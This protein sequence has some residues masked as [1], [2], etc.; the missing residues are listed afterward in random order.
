[1]IRSGYLLPNISQGVAIALLSWLVVLWLVVAAGASDGQVSSPEM[2]LLF[3]SGNDQDVAALVTKR[4]GGKILADG[5][6]GATIR[7]GAGEYLVL[8]AQRVINPRGGAV[9]FWVRPQWKPEDRGS[10]TF[11][12][13]PWADSRTGY[14]A[15]SY[16]W[17]EPAGKDLTYVIGNNLEHANVARLIRYDLH[18]WTH[19]VCVWGEGTPGFIRLY[20]NGLKVGEDNRYGGDYQA[21]SV[22]H[23]GAD[24]GTPLAAGRWA[25]ADFSGVSF[26][27][28]PLSD[29]AV[30]KLYQ[31]DAAAGHLIT[32]SRD[33]VSRQIRA[34]FDEGVGWMSERGARETIRRIKAAGFNVFIPCVW[35]GG[36]T[37]YPSDSA[38]PEHK[39]MVAGTD[40]LKR[41]IDI[42]HANA[43]EVHPWF[44]VTLRENA[45]FPEYFDTNTPA[46]AYDI[47]R[48]EFQRF[49]VELIADVAR[50]YQID[51]VNLD[52]IRTMG[53]CTCSFCTREY[54]HQ[55]G[56]DLVVD[57]L[58]VT[59]GVP[60]EPALQAW[61][62]DAVESLVRQISQRVKS[63]RPTAI[64][65]VDGHPQ[66]FDDREGRQEA[67]WTNAEL[68]DL[69]FN[70]DY[71]NP[72]DAE[73]HHGV[74]TSFQ[75]PWRLI[76]LISNY[77]WDGQKVKPKSAG[78]LRRNVDYLLRRWPGGIGIYLYSMLNDEQAGMFVSGPF[79]TN[80]DKSGHNITGKRQPA[81]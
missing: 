48:H 75:E 13:F 45:A 9:S 19:L 62:D 35:H 2:R 53:I 29:E 18:Q 68:V 12:S 56:R 66:P 50:R 47:H 71:G 20:V 77:D 21:G 24:K 10:H 49:M 76:P 43:I 30:F 65:S 57:V 5:I 70:M 14:F 79:A 46:K 38:P 40:P 51:G 63:L 32:T 61:Q 59:P 73:R 25:H 15:V 69:V 3:R 37:R 7:L 17:W 44:T 34:I 11:L 60:L 39:K 58:A 36:G 64:I 26:F 33:P 80:Y 52:Y 78:T 81:P 22:L 72:P 41:L 16:G 31:R 4:V 27:Q 23:L 54:H 67:R 1:M 55:T 42:A 6:P 8:D 28:T 74:K